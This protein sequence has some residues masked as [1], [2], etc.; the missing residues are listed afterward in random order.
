MPRW[1]S[2]VAHTKCLLIHIFFGRRLVLTLL[3]LQYLQADFQNSLT[4]PN[5]FFHLFLVSY[6]IGSICF[7]SPLPVVE[8][9]ALGVIGRWLVSPFLYLKARGRRNLTMIV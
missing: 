9:V 4:I 2:S 5:L 3:N 6:G 7:S 8:G 1:T